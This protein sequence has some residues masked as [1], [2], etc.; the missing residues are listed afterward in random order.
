MKWKERIPLIFAW[1]N[2]QQVRFLLG[3]GYTI[4]VVSVVVAVGLRRAE[5]LN[6]G[7]LVAIWALFG[8]GAACMLGQ[9]IMMLWRA[10][11][12]F[13]HPD[14]CFIKTLPRLGIREVRK[15]LEIQK[16][17]TDKS[18]TKRLLE[19]AEIHRE[20]TSGRSGVIV[21]GA[22]VLVV[23]IFGS[24]LLGGIFG[25]STESLP[26][27]LLLTGC[28]LA[29]IAWFSFFDARQESGANYVCSALKLA[30]EHDEDSLLLLLQMM[31]R[32]DPES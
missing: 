10:R 18:K 12:E 8:L 3:A 17:F 20:R 28:V 31:E 4:I 22:T 9:G 29:G 2:R 5:L 14:V 23:G 15:A 25:D 21:A 19:L 30:N 7:T 24:D 6:I 32:K 1:A 16:E 11:E 13:L 26:S 27:L